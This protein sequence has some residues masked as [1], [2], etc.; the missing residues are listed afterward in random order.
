MRFAPAEKRSASVADDQRGE[1][2]R[3]LANAGAIISIAS[4]PM[5]FIF[6]WNSR[7]RTPSP[8]STRLAPGL[9]LT[10]R[11]RAL[12]DRRMSRSDPAG[13]RRRA[14]R[15]AAGVEGPLDERRRIGHGAGVEDRSEADG[16]P[17]LEWPQLPAEAPPHRPIDVVDRRGDVRRH[18]GRVDQRGPEG[19]PQQIA[20]LVPAEKQGAQPFGGRRPGARGVQRCQ[21]RADALA[22]FERR[23]VEREDARLAAL[24]SGW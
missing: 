17:R 14:N 21:L 16:V 12:A 3:G 13:E 8:R 1:I 23:R 22:E 19:T 15:V 4:P 10:T 6:E 5:V 20:G 24:G 18:A 2:G 9:V 7:P 11:A